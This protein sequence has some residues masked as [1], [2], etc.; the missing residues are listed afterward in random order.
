MSTECVATLVTKSRVRISIGGREL[1]TLTAGYFVLDEMDRLLS[2]EGYAR[3]SSWSDVGP[4]RDYNRIGDSWM[5]MVA[6]IGED[7]E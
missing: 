4:E 6:R 2:T 3:T 5:A 1:G 7:D